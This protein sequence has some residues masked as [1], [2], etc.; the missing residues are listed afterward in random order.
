MIDTHHH[1]WRYNP[2]EYG[3]ISDAMSTIRRD[4]LPAD[5]HTEILAAGVNSVISVQ[6]RQCLAETKWLLDFASRYKFISAV[7]GWVPL[8]SPDVESLLPE[9]TAEPKL[10]SV[11][12]V[13][14]DEPDDNYML[15]DDFNRG[16]SVLARYDLAYDILIFARHLPQTITLV[17][18]HPDQIFILD[19]IAKPDIRAGKL[20]P[21]RTE[22]RELARRP[23]VFCKLSGMVTEA[24][25]H[26]WTPAAL[27]PYAQTVLECFGPDRLMI[28]SDW[29]VCLVACD[30]TRWIRTARELLA[31]LSAAEQHKI[32]HATPMRAYHIR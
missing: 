11:R 2:T 19:H 31:T 3:W 26:T 12:H 27:A 9:L 24:D 7:V 17:D 6:A 10:R 13:L 1:F 16:I 4:F 8:I 5:L 21:W 30:Y 29:P 32:E 25:W 18:R 14:H 23:N 22:L 15:R 20:E 28:G